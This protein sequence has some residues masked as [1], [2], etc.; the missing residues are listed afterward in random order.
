MCRRW[1]SMWSNA[2]GAAA[3]AALVGAGSAS[4]EEPFARVKAAPAPRRAAPAAE[5]EAPAP[6]AAFAPDRPS[7]SNATGRVPAGAVMV[8]L[9]T[10]LSGGGWTG[11]GASVRTG[12]LPA[13]ELRLRL[14]G[15]ARAPGPRGPVDGAPARVGLKVGGGDAGPVAWSLMPELIA[16]PAGP[17]GAAALNLGKGLGSFGLFASGRVDLLPGAAPHPA[18][19]AGL[20]FAPGAL[21][22]YGQAGHDGQPFAGGGAALLLAPQTQADVGVD[23]G[24]DGTRTL[25]MG[26]SV[27]R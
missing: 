7:L 24:L 2:G 25:H 9:G 22:V 11:D 8:E 5:E 17:G 18:G 20:G 4:A 15:L 21:S 27:Q 10:N 26:L 1:T 12:L 6:P 13:L 16:D 19:G 14:P 3:V 23:V